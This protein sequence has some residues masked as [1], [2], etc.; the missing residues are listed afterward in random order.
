[1]AKRIYYISMWQSRLIDVSNYKINT[2][3]DQY[4]E[5][6]MES[7]KK[8]NES[9]SKYQRILHNPI[10]IPQNLTNCYGPWSFSVFQG[11]SPCYFFCYCFFLFQE[12]KRM[13]CSGLSLVYLPFNLFFFF[14]S[15]YFYFHRFHCPLHFYFEWNINCLPLPWLLC[16]FP[17][18]ILDRKI[19]FFSSFFFDLNQAIFVDLS[20]LPI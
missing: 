4:I 11:N 16:Y 5:K 15:I 20:F 1:M 10:I 7:R 18:V 8:R 14:F 12:K 17:I 9:F 3:I 19:L 13:N 2:C 6:E